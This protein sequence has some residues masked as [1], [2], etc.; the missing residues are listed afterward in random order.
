MCT[1]LRFTHAGGATALIE[2]RGVRFLTDPTFDAAGTEFRSGSYV[3]Q[4]TTDPAVSADS[5][6]PVD[7]VLLSHDHH[8][9]NLD[10]SGRE[11]L[12]RADRVLTTQAGASRL[13]GNAIGLS[14]WERYTM[15]APEGGEI[16]VTATP[17]RHGPED[18]D[19]VPVTGFVLTGPTDGDGTTYISGDTVWYVRRRGGRP[20]LSRA[21]RVSVY[22]S[23]RSGVSEG[24]TCMASAVGGTGYRRGFARAVKPGTARALR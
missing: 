7:A 21:V 20:A 14:P 13:G 18:G 15:A 9:D 23:D 24:R 1:R 17:A 2:F 8:F 19:C 5:L 16:T 6:L 12:G 10:G 11:F 4:R 22:G 3:R